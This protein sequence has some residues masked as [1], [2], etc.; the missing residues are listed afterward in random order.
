MPLGLLFVALATAGGLVAFA[1]ARPYFS[2]GVLAF[3]RFQA[4]AEGRLV[5]GPSIASQRL[6]LDS[7][8]HAMTS[9]YGRMQPSDRRTAVYAG[10][11]RL[12]DEVTMASPTF[13]YAWFVGAL[14]AERLG[15]HEAMNSKLISSQVTGPTE[16]WIAELRADLAERHLSDLTP[17]ARRGHDRDLMMLVSSDRGV[18][19]MARR[20]TRDPEFRARIV[21]LVEAMPMEQQHRFLRS[22]EAVAGRAMG[23]R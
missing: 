9:V 10:C 20:Y 18:R 14:A 2:G 1:E 21:P 17:E 23:R 4:I 3:E 7:C 16:Q 5:P 13:S 22:I 11:S 19:S 6:V 12:A 15:D 8:A